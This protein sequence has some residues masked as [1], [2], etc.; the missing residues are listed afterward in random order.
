LGRL[1][2]EFAGIQAMEQLDAP[3]LALK[4]YLKHIQ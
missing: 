1:A 3:L 4:I 2:G